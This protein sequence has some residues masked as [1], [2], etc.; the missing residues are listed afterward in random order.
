MFWNGNSAA[1]LL[2]IFT[3]NISPSTFNPGGK[4]QPLKRVTLIYQETGLFLDC[5]C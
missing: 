1:Q 4:Q 5:D 2:L 3:W